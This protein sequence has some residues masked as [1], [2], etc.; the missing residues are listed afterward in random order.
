MVKLRNFLVFIFETIFRWVS[1]PVEPGLLEFGKPNK[2]SPVFITANYDL[3]VRRVIKH[4]RQLS[5]YLLVAP[6]K[7]I[8]VWCASCGGD[9]N[10]HSVISVIK[11]SG[12]SEKVSHRTLIA[13]QLS[14]PGINVENVRKET[15][16]NIKFGPVYARD[17][18]K[19]IKEGYK[20]TKEMKMV[21][22]GI[23]PRVEM[24]SVYFFSLF[25][26]FTPI[27]WAIS[28]FFPQIVQGSVAWWIL[29]F[30]VL[31]VTMVY[32]LYLLLP[33][34]PIKSGLARITIGEILVLL[35]LELYGFALYGN[36]LH[37]TDLS[38][39]SFVIASL[40]GID[41]NGNTPT[42]KSGLGE[43]FYKRGAK[44]MAFITGTYKLTKYGEI[45]IEQEKCI[46]CKMC[47]EVCPR[48]VYEFNENINKA[49]L[50][51]PERCV[52]C[53]ACVKQCLGNC[54]EI[55]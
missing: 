31:T 4:L 34:L 17:I 42:E 49:I 37:Y 22:F 21:R 33:S 14:A 29:R 52:N 36:F 26:I 12:I 18:P 20:K 10:E 50:L 43:F 24:A 53:G 25:L 6:T 39:F 40:L 54:L 23:K 27:L 30:I 48:D 1:V 28:M 8:N 2:D 19:Y 47:I 35:S 3:T 16:W 51:H 45:T 46:G 5:C 41:F 11:T 44:K 38:L 15:G 9:F 13:P 7:G 55:K 32:G